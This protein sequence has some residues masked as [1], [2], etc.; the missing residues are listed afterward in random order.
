MNKYEALFLLFV[1]VSV[2]SIFFA[3]LKKVFVCLFLCTYV[4]YYFFLV[5]CISGFRFSVFH[6]ALFF[7]FSVFFVPAA[8]CFVCVKLSHF[9][10]VGSILCDAS[11]LLIRQ[12][13]LLACVGPPQKGGGLANRILASEHQVE[14]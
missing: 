11:V 7:F 12:L 1:L 2:L 5:C 14:M 9:Q 13:D 3:T 8:R 6:F 10:L 4:L